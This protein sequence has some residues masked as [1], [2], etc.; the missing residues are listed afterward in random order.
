M[1]FDRPQLPC[2]G[3]GAGGGLGNGLLDTQ[4]YWKVS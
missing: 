2:T 3:A 1:I 4:Q